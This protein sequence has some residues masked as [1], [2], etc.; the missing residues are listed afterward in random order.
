MR[1]ACGSSSLMTPERTVVR[2]ASV[3]ESLPPRARSRPFVQPTSRSNDSVSRYT[4]EVARSVDTSARKASAA[5]VTLRFPSPT[6]RAR[7]PCKRNQGEQTCHHCTGQHLQCYLP[8]RVRSERGSRARILPRRRK[9]CRHAQCGCLPGLDGSSFLG[10]GR[11]FD[12]A[13][14]NGR[15]YSA[16][17]SR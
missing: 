15:K 8:R 17:T 9:F 2:I 14:G 3:S 7:C 10:H 11:P 6:Y 13:V 16:R 1:T 5:S 4:F 12:G